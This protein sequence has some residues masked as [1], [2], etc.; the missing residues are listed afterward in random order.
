[1]QEAKG[2][3]DLQDETQGVAG[4]LG[5][6]LKNGDVHGKIIG[7][8]GNIWESMGTSLKIHGT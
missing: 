6:P 4:T 5:H 8:Y 1:L 7:I 3:L 2:D